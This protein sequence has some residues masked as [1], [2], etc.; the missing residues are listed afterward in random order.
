[1][2]NTAHSP[3][4][5][6]R[7]RLV[8]TFADLIA[9]RFEG[10]IN[11]ICWRRQLPG[12]FQEIVTQLHA[13]AGMTTL[14]DDDLRALKLSTSGA[15]ARK[16]LLADQ[17]LLRDH[18][19]APSLDIIIGYPRDDAASPVATDVHSF[20]VDSAPVAT[21][22]FLCTY[23][24]ATSEGL[25]NEAAVRRV[26]VAETRAQL[27]KIYGGPDDQNFSAYLSEHS[28]D[29]HYAAQPGAQPYV[30]GNGNLW[31]LAIAYPG[32]PV[33]PCIHRAPMTLPGAPARLLLIS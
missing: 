8:S 25:V 1:M 23:V 22:T 3:Q 17:D 15:I 10:D 24:G 4:S 18:G 32:A 14:E 5:S 27:L 20:H 21:D 28:F 16:V 30:F 19:L 7:V 13:E 33:L 2:E 31:R 12:D 29:L 26:E 9:A 11:A 6:H